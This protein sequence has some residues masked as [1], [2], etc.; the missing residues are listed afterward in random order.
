MPLYTRCPTKYFFAN[1][2]KVI[3]DVSK[4]DRGKKPNDQIGSD[5]V[6]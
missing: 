2:A 5:D 3:T 6:V 1:S 4:S